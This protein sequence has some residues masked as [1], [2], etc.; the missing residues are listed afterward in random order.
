MSHEHLSQIVESVPD[1]VQ[2]VVIGFKWFMGE[3]QTEGGPWTACK[4]KYIYSQ[5]ISEP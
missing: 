1:A 2:N 3:K 4:L 5:A